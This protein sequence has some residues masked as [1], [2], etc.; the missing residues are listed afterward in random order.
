M[1][2]FQEESIEEFREFLYEATVE[3]SSV[4]NSLWLMSRVQH[5]RKTGWVFEVISRGNSEKI[6]EAEG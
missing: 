2:I 4:S 1:K 6:L 5:V 3:E